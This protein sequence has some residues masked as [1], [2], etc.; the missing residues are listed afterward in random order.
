MQISMTT[1]LITAS[2]NYF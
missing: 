1:R 2:L